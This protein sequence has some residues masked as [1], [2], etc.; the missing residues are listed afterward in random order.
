[1]STIETAPKT[2]GVTG[3]TSVGLVGLMALQAWV[4]SASLLPKS[5]VQ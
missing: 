4:W 3:G 1:M 2:T 5:A